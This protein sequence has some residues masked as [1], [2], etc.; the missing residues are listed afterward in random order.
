MQA[1]SDGH[2]RALPNETPN[3]DSR[4]FVA[5]AVASGTRLFPLQ[6]LFL[7]KANMTAE[8]FYGGEYPHS[9]K[10]L[11]LGLCRISRRSA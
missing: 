5:K 3:V 9:S 10:N 2:P 4:I 7:R 11:Q 6:R 1:R 8:Q